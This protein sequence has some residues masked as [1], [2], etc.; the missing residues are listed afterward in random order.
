METPQPMR[1]AWV[2]WSG[3]KRLTRSFAAW[4]LGPQEWHDAP[5]DRA[6]PG[7]PPRVWHGGHV[8]QGLHAA[9][10]GR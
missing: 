7:A 1:A 3:D 8:P 4:L 2:L 9:P 5:Q 10:P 6:A